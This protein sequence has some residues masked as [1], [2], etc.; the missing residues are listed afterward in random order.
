MTKDMIIPQWKRFQKTIAVFLLSIVL[1]ISAVN[2]VTAQDNTYQ[3][4]DALMV[5]LVYAEDKADDS[6]L[7]IQF[8]NVTLQKALELLTEEINVGFSYNPDVIPNKKVSFSMSNVPPYEVI[9]KLLEGTNLE[10]VIPPSK[11][12]IVIREKKAPIP[13]GDGF[14]QTITGTVVDAQTAESIPGVNIVFKGTSQGTSTDVNGSYSLEV[15]SLAGTLIFSYIGYQ[16]TEVPIAGRTTIDIEFEMQVL[17]GEEMVVT[18]FGLERERESVGYSVSEVRGESLARVRTSNV[19]DNLSGRVA[20]VNASQMGGGMAGNS[21]RILIRGTGS[22]Q[23]DNQPLYVVN[24]MP[25]SNNRRL[26]TAFHGGSVS[27]KGD[28]IQHLNSDDIESITVLKGGAAAALYGSKAA[29]GVILITT[30]TGSIAGDDKITVELNSNFTVGT[31][32]RYP[33]L[34]QQYGQGVGGQR[35]QTQQEAFSSGRLA[36]GE[37]IEDV[38]GGTAMNFDGVRRPYILYPIKRQ[39]KEFYR[40]STELNNNLAFSGGIGGNTSYRLSLSDLQAE[41][42]QPNSNYDRKTVNLSVNASPGEKLSISGFAQYTYDEGNNRPTSN[43]APDN[44]NWGVTM[45]ANT[46]PIEALAPGYYPDTMKEKEWQHVAIATNPY[47]VINRLSNEDS[48]NRIVSQASATYTPTSN[49]YIKADIMRDF[50]VF[51]SEYYEPIGTAATPT[52]QYLRTDQVNSNLTI[53]TLAGYDTSYGD[54]SISTMAGGSIERNNT[55]STNLS[56]VDF[57]IPEFHSFVNLGTTNT[58]TGVRKEGV[59]SLFASADLSYKEI[60]HLSFTGRQDWFS[61]LRVEDNNIFY[62]SVGGSFVLSNLWDLPEVISFARLRASWARIG[63]A[64][65]SPYAINETFRFR[66]GGHMGVPVQLTSTSEVNPNLRP[67]TSTTR[68]VGFDLDLYNGRFGID[69][70][71]YERKNEDDIISVGLPSSSGATSTIINAGEINNRGVE[72]LLTAETVRGGDF[73][74]NMGFNFAYNRNRVKALAPGTPEG[75][76]SL[77]GHPLSQFWLRDMAYTEDGTPIYNSTSRYELRTDPQPQGPGVPPWTTGL[78]NNFSYKNISLNILIDGK[79]G[80]NFFSQQARYFHRFG[81][82][83][84]TLPGREDG[85]NLTGVD[86]NG[87]P[88]QQSWP[89]DFMATYYNNQGAYHAMFVQDGSFIKLRSASLTYNVPLHKIGLS[90]YVSGAEISLVGRNLAILYSQTEHFDP[91]QN[92]NPN[93]NTQNSIGTQ[94]P[95]TRTIGMNINLKF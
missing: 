73:S 8:A 54:F 63:S 17:F 83:K 58:E 19:A 22:T 68:E 72:L 12:V 53:Q 26:Q 23:G 67:L 64:T 60:I 44:T 79:F 74:W 42:I 24:G 69:L 39:M 18:A 47:F 85:L 11:D 55:S 25:I 2:P 81:H 36:F 35:P 93:S 21:S 27:D 76:T 30:K 43:Y 28:G 82:A 40:P 41:S 7:S 94:L 90:N 29:N 51:H 62:P 95:R 10:S 38:D 33:N 59:N 52:G 4:N 15:E 91:E 48:K 87:D 71:L 75:G 61:T 16:T 77:I 80:N 70:T 65:V 9:Y 13:A 84:E 14:Q 3:E 31:I 50:E 1:L 66:T 46:I 32:N 78:I 92:Y 37:R 49:S 57:I 6:L 89:A 20:G 34:Q 45:L 5:Q 86:E 88:F 56:G